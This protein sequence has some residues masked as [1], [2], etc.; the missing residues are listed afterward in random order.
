M[1]NIATNTLFIGK[2]LIYLPTCHSTND[3]AREIASSNQGYEGATVITSEQTA[4]KGQRG[5]KWEAEPGKNL[6]LSIILKPKSLPIAR[7][8]SLNMSIS[9]AVYE[10]LTKYLGQKVK[11]KWPNDVLFEDKKLCGILIENSV[12]GQYI[13]TSIAGIGINVN[14]EKFNE[15]NAVSL[16]MI[17]GN[18]IPLET[19]AANLFESIEAN[20]LGI[21][22]KEDALKV[23]YLESLYRL[24]EEHTYKSGDNYFK[25]RICNVDETGQLIIK[26]AEGERSFQFKEVQYIL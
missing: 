2:P 17:L 11:I 21:V 14:Q 7:Q 1:Y 6:T 22:H 26:T 18:E 19:I 16:K 8:F 12:R 15:P 23:R 9:L 5:N 4:G 20:Y 3:I 13:E 25:G 10:V 24:H